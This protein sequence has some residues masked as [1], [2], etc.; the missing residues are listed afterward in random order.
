MKTKL[1]IFFSIFPFC[2]F[3][4]DEQDNKRSPLFSHEKI[5][6]LYFKAR[7]PFL[8]L[9][10]DVQDFAPKIKAVQRSNKNEFFN[11]VNLFTGI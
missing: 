3:A 9:K 1:Y 2:C 5:I 10:K 7:Q 11:F 8:P 6:A 4:S